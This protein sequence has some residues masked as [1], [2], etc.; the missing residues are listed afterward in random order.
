MYSFPLVLASVTFKET[1]LTVFSEYKA[2]VIHLLAVSAG[3]TMPGGQ[4]SRDVGGRSESSDTVAE[5][6]RSL[7]S[8]QK[9][10]EH[11]LCTH[12][13]LNLHCVPASRLLKS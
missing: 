7:F 6:G 12:H 10:N 13:F 9:L 11:V 3:R 8:K 5:P 4:F 2:S 1:E